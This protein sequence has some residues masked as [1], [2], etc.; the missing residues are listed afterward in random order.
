[1]NKHNFIKITLSMLLACSFLL[2]GFPFLANAATPIVR[3]EDGKISFVITSTAATSSIKYRT[4]GW[5]VRR[6]QLCTNTT[7]KQC[8]N[9]KSGQHASFLDQQVRQVDQYPNPPIPGQPVTTYYEVSE[10]L[11]TEGMWKAGMGD[12]KDNDDLYLYAIM[13]SID[14]NGNVRKGPFYTLDE[15]KRAEPWAHPDDLDDYFGLHV[16]YRSADFPVDVIAKTVTGKVI[17]QPQVTFQKGKY[18]VGETINHEFPETIEDNGKTYSI[19]RSYLSPKQDSTKKDWLQENPE[20]NPK[21]QTRSFTVHLGGTDAIAEYAENNPV[22]AIYQKEDGTKLKEVDKGVFATGEE[23]NHTFEGQIISGGQTYE[24]IRSYITN[25]NKPDEKLFI[26]EK[27]DPKLKE[28]S[29]LVGTGGSNFIGIYKIPSSITVT[30]RIEAPETVDKNV[31]EVDGNF[32]FEV[33]SL[34]NLKSYEITDIRNARL[35]QMGEK[36]GT[37]SGTSDSKTIPIKIPFT[38]GDKASVQITVVVKDVDANTGD[39]TSDHTV[40]KSDGGGDTQ[41]GASQQAEVMEPTVSAVI[42]ADSR[43]AEKFDVLQ[44][45]PT[46]ESLYVNAL[47]KS[48]LYRSTFTE[49]TGTKQ[50]PIQVS[51]TY[52]LTWTETHPGSPDANGNSTT[53]TVPRS[54]T[55]TVT[56]NYSIERKY[57]FWT[58]QNLEVYGIQKATVSNYALPSGTVTLVPSGYTPPTVSASHDA[59]LGAHMTDPVYSNVTLPGQTISGGSSRPSVPNEDWKNEAEKA[60]GKIKVKND[61]LLF[62]GNTIMDNRI[63]EEKAPTPGAIPA[64]PMIGQDVLYGKGYLIDASKMNK[65]NQPSTG[66][67]SYS[68]IK[69]I[70]GGGD[71]TYPIGGIN[72]VTV[73]SPVVNYAAVSDDQAHNQKTQPTAGRSALIL[74]RPFT[75]TIPTNGQHKDIKG[76]GNRDYAKYVR[77]KQVWFPFDVFKADRTTFVPKETWVSIPVGQMQ[78]TFF[79]PVWVDEGN[80][81]VLFRTFAEN[82]PASFTSQMNANLDLSNHVA[83]QVVPVEVIGRLYDFRITDIADFAWESVFRTQKGSAKP[84]GNAYWVG[85]KGIDGASRGN[86]PPYVLP[87]RQGSH[88]ESGKKNVAVK[89]GYHFKFEVMTKGNMFS[90]GDGIRITPT[91]YFVDSKGKTRQEVDLY[92]HSGNQRFI[93]IG[94][95]DDVEKRYVTLDA[96]LR[97]VPRQELTDTAATLWSLNGSPGA[98][99]TFIDQY[100]KD[101]QKPT[102]VGGYDIML[103]PPQLR[104]FVGS[105][106]VPSG[107]NAAR[108]NASVQKWYAEYSLPAAPYV[109]PKGFNL[110]EYGRNNRLYDKSP[111]FLKDGYIIVNFNL[112]TIRN[113][114]LNH[115][116]LQYIYGPLNNQWQ[117]EGFQR[118]LIDPYG[119]TFSLRYGD[120]IFYHANLSSYDDYGTGGTH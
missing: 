114:D 45:I 112:E 46:S 7:P 66:T 85:T 115:S 20:T 71:K 68:L 63:V 13:V 41:P 95:G 33:K 8:G 106:N 78:T 19:V 92:Y 57:S 61:S 28:R 81:N 34:K 109:V 120:V 104:T 97:N 48:Y 49:T 64:P 101:A 69:G 27:G 22:K 91:F 83:T 44:G 105:M 118:S 99:Q 6:D 88:P 9:P 87:V 37:L 39:S 14:G 117:M 16:P 80:Y 103:L 15:I 73:H 31:T 76:Y 90:A 77:D 82:S 113:R 116:H 89:T 54:D 25:N 107:I 30:S 10:A 53:I 111:I 67:I 32:V 65:A 75:V 29:I 58:I 96:R 72:P 52:T 86:T 56:K 4:V 119:V 108:A 38:T 23:A 40:R 93:R 43:G 50:Y 24:I 5:T 42:Q 60:I 110:A 26:Q 36:T 1:M 98:K 55:Q 62:I 51:K 2:S 47:A 17:N 35:V 102:Y 94:S 12:I 74:D 21:V 79:L 100:M 59:S 3:V 18:K 84:T 70:G 11:V